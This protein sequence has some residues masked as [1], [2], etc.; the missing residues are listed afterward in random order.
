MQPGG[1]VPYSDS[2][3]FEIS[4]ARNHVYNRKQRKNIRDHVREWRAKRLNHTNH[5]CESGYINHCHILLLYEL[6]KKN[7]RQP[8]FSCSSFDKCDFLEYKPRYYMYDC[9]KTMKKRECKLTRKLKNNL[10]SWCSSDPPSRPLCFLPSIGCSFQI[11]I[12]VTTFNLRYVWLHFFLIKSIKII[13]K[14]MF[15]GLFYFF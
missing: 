5:F 12:E 6:I 9:I 7:T 10:F 15:N 2:L 14:N 8:S 11:P 13:I 4:F 3:S 1:F